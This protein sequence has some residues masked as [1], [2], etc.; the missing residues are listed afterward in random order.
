VS[1]IIITIVGAV[2]AGLG[3][4]VSRYV[5][6]W[7]RARTD[8]ETLGA[9]LTAIRA[10]VTAAY[11]EGVKNGWN[12]DTQKAWAISKATEFGLDLTDA[13]F[14]LLRKAAVAEIKG[15]SSAAYAGELNET[16]GKRI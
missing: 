3:A 16:G 13:Q 9:A 4:L 15:I 6:P 8:A 7:I 5:I 1:D 11:N 2:I 12:G 10:V 14:D